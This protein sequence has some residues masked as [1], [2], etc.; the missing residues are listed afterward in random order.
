MWAV[1]APLRNP[2]AAPMKILH[3][4]KILATS[5][6]QKKGLLNTYLE[7]TPADSVKMIETV[8][9]IPIIRPR[10]FNQRSLLLIINL[11]YSIHETHIY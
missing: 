9:K 11:K 5:S 2:M 4:S 3:M 6:V 1:D 7:I 10:N 8:Q